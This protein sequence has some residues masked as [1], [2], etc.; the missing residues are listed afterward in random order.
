MPRDFDDLTLLV[1]IAMAFALPYLP[2]LLSRWSD[3]VLPPQWNAPSESVVN[4]QNGIASESLFLDPLQE[5][6]SLP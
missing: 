6:R 4:D 2:F 5:K 1:L 3:F